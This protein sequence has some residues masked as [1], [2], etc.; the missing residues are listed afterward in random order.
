[1]DNIIISIL[2]GALAGW[3]ASK[4]MKT[5]GGI[6]RNVI[7]GIVGGFV[8]GLVFGLIGIGANNYLGTIIISVV[9][10]CIVI[11]VAKLITKY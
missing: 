5:G 1:M 7:L 9:G 8:G 2:I 6:I 4:I 3:I 10:A 11:F